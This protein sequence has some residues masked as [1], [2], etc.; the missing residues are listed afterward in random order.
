MVEKRIFCFDIEVEWNEI[1]PFKIVVKKGSSPIQTIGCWDSYNNR[2]YSFFYHKD[3]QLKEDIHKTIFKDK[4][5]KEL[6]NHKERENKILKFLRK[7]LNTN[8][9]IFHD[10]KF[11]SSES[12]NT[13]DCTYILFQREKVMLK[14]FM[15]FIND[16]SP[17]IYTGFNVEEFDLV[18]IINRCK[19]L[20]INYKYLSVLRNAY[21]SH[22]RASIRGNIIH[23]FQALYG[24]YMGTHRHKNSLKK[25][26]ESHLSLSKTSDNIL[27]EDWY[28]KKQKWKEFI[29]Y[30]LVDVELCVLLEDSLGLIRQAES[31]SNFTGVD[32]K[33]VH[34]D[35]HIM[36]SIAYFIKPIYEREIL[37]EKYKIAFPTKKYQKIPRSAGGFVFKSKKGL[38]LLGLIII[39]DLSKMYPNIVKSLNISP[40][41]LIKKIKESEKSYYI[42]CKENNVYY[43]KSR[44]G[45]VPFLF[46]F[47]ISIR[48]R[49]E[50][51]RNKHKYG[52]KKYKELNQKRQAV[53]DTVNAVTGQYDYAQSIIVSPECADSI[54]LTGQKE[55]KLGA[56]WALIFSKMLS[57]VHPIDIDILYGDTDSIFPNIRNVEDVDVCVRL[58]KEIC[59]WIQIGFDLLAKELNIDKHYFNMGIEKV[60][61]VFASTGKKKKYFGHVLW[62]DGEYVNEESSFYIR[63]FESR[64]TDSSEMTDKAQKEIFGII[65][66]AKKIGW[67]KA[68][69]R[70]FIKVRRE[71]PKEFVWDN[72]LRIGIP[73]GINK[74]IS[75]YKVTNPWIEGADY[76]NRYLNAN[77]GKGSKPK[78]IYIKNVK[79]VGINKNYSKYPPTDRIC[80]EDGVKVPKEIF[81][82]DKDKMIEKTVLDK[83]E[84]VLEVV[85]LSISE[86]VDGLKETSILDFI[87]NNTSKR[88]KIDIID[89][90]D[91][92]KILK[93]SDKHLNKFKE[94]IE[95]N[96]DVESYIL[97][98]IS[99]SE[100][101]EV[102]N[103]IS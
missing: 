57:K 60:M 17:D 59:K 35:S 27:E 26:A 20:R 95:Q 7:K 65:C 32:P 58:S 22:G 16:L 62:S 70:I 29:D 64:R 66:D 52:T 21:V 14:S 33:F 46:D 47:I 99:E 1:D 79:N 56:I 85:D 101:K 89:D 34:Y 82:I 87:N 11:V 73:K 15:Y 92:E 88:K 18:Y 78:L 80:I 39:L 37:N 71:Y 81:V 49:V 76:A 67:E 91:L 90:K 54:R 45:F 63:G 40:E 77:F 24:D 25:V 41:T 9:F 55:I 93:E 48:T 43:D 42:H 30:C 98:N 44:I 53:K 84:D 69:K 86:V 72:A 83:I 6:D 38:Y 28:Y 36:E 23:D 12:G 94:L 51:Q 5:I 2:Y 75:D 50:K 3:L 68:K 103:S 4:K 100:L 102:Y 31:L 13:Y 74:K 8:E 10:G 96:K 19:S 61:D 97:K